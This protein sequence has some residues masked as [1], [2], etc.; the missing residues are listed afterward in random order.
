LYQNN[1]PDVTPPNLSASSD[2]FSVLN[3]APAM[4]VDNKATSLPVILLKATMIE[5]NGLKI[6]D[7]M[8]SNINLF[9]LDISVCSFFICFCVSSCASNALIVSLVCCI[10]RSN[11]SLSVLLFL[12]FCYTT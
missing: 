8:P 7:K 9:L 2:I 11:I 12:F 10:F 1:S 4:V 5:F 6:K 3:T